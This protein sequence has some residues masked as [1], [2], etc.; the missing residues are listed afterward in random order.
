MSPQGFSKQK[1]LLL[2]L[3]FFSF[4]LRV[5][6]ANSNAFSLNWDEVSHGYNAY[7]ILK[8]G[9][10][11]WGKIFPLIFRAYGDYKLPVYIYLVAIFEAFLGLSS[12]AV[13]LPSL[14]AGALTVIFSYLLVKELTK[15]RLVAFLTAILVAVEPWVLFLSGVG[16]EANLSILLIVSGM[17]FFFSGIKEKSWKLLLSVVFL[18]LS[19]WTYNSARIFVP[20]LI[21]TSFLIYRKQILKTFEMKK[22]LATHYLL[23]ATV[24]FV[25]MFVQ[26]LNPSGLARYAKVE[27]LDKG[28]IQKINDLRTASQL[29]KPV[30][31]IIY[32][33]ATYV[34]NEFVA[35]YFSYSSFQFLFLKGGTHYQFSVPNHGVLYLVDIPFWFLGLFVLVSQLKKLP[36]ARFFLAWF[37]LAPIAGSLTREAPHVLRGIVFIPIPMFLTSVGVMEAGKRLKKRGLLIGVYFVLIL[38]SFLFYF[39][40]LPEYKIKYS[41]AWQYGYKEVVNFIKE[42]YGSYDQIIITKKYG[43]PHEFI[44]FYWPWDPGSYQNDPKL[45]RFYQS[46]WWWVDAFAKFVFINDW[47]V[48]KEG[49]KFVTEGK[50]LFDCSDKRCLLITSFENRPEDWRILG[51]IKFLDGSVAFEMYEN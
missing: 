5:Y 44:L 27:I 28:S 47:D 31:R 9:K 41:W 18:G 45:D 34:T 15:E 33:K 48:P 26:L 32:N 19:V 3:L 40:K 11:E 13:R 4:A 16:V 51:N 20:L 22:F 24:F 30:A 35:N 39:N 23:L 1:Y 38:F 25:P 8:T 50:R 2:A 49:S 37:L 43:E 21:F 17:Y 29:P 14:I 46:G 7:S 12:I 10:D 6:L 42:V 36:Q